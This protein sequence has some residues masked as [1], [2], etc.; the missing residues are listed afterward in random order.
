MIP[1]ET[2]QAMHQA[3]TPEL[4]AYLNRRH[5]GNDQIDAYL[6]GYSEL[7]GQFWI[8]IPIFDA[9]SNVIFVKLKRPPDAPED[10]PKGMTHP[11]GNEATLYPIQ[12]LA[13]AEEV[14][15]CEGEPDCLALLTHGINAVCSTAGAGTWNEEWCALFPR[16]CRVVLC[17]DM[18]AAGIA[19]QAKV[20]AAF[21][22]KRPDIR[23][24]EVRFPET[25][26]QYGKDVTDYFQ[27]PLLWPKPSLPPE[28]PHRE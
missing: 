6:L 19:G 5:I 2:I 7:N 27:H 13:N 22:A 15:I 4:R 17:Y 12:N 10:Q 11:A 18:D 20:K 3:L 25:L 1:L 24:G 9:E 14:V 28:V 16:E 8:T 23:L 21:T 26:K